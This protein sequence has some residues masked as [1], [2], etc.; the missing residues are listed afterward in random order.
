MHI[1]RVGTMAVIVSVITTTGPLSPGRARGE[2]LGPANCSR[3]WGIPFG[4]TVNHI[5]ARVPNVPV[6]I[7]EV[8]GHSFHVFGSD[9]LPVSDEVLFVTVGVADTCG[10]FKIT[11]GFRPGLSPTDPVMASAVRAYGP[12]HAKDGIGVYWDDGTHRVMCSS[13][14]QQTVIDGFVKAVWAPQLGPLRNQTLSQEEAVDTVGRDSERRAGDSRSDPGTGGHMSFLSRLFG[15]ESIPVSAVAER[16][17]RLLLPSLL[18]FFEE[19]EAMLPAHPSSDVLLRLLAL[20]QLRIERAFAS[21]THPSAARIRDAMAEQYHGRLFP[22]LCHDLGSADGYPSLAA[23]EFVV[24]VLIELEDTLSRS[25][26]TGLDGAASGR[27]LTRMRTLR[28]ELLQDS[29]FLPM[30]AVPT[31]VIDLELDELIWGQARLRILRY[32]SVLGDAWDSHLDHHLGAQYWAVKKAVAD[33]LPGSDRQLELHLL[34]Q[35][36]DTAVVVMYVDFLRK[37]TSSLRIGE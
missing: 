5:R 17:P 28:K 37:V 9:S 21:V 31:R 27:I 12:P 13:L 1:Y 3:V 34:L 25:G 30:E 18:R 6:R 19:N 26:T 35:A 33:M 22:Q 15:Q 7:E 24:G 8:D 14:D 16:W 10:V 23:R 29:P 4:C 2:E 32:A 11:V 20:D 36:H